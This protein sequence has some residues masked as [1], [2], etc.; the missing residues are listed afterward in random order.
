MPSKYWLHLEVK[1]AFGWGSNK[2]K[3]ALFTKDGE[4]GVNCQCPAVASVLLCFAFC[5]LF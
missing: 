2:V 5:C 3:E 1:N 4:G